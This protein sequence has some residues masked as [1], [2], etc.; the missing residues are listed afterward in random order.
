MN[1][2]WNALLVNGR[3]NGTPRR[4]RT[5][6]MAVHYFEQTFPNCFHRL[7][8]HDPVKKKPLTIAPVCTVLVC[9]H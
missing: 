7:A 6:L 3:F 8:L 9:P 1:A 5:A 2:I 4:R